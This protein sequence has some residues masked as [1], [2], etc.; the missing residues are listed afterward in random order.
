[1]ASLVAA[2][3][4]EFVFTLLFAFF[5]GLAPA[6]YAAVANG[7]ALSVLVYCAVSQSGG[8][9]NP[10]VTVALVASG[11]TSVAQGAA[12]VLC[13]LAGAIVGAGVTKGFL[14]SPGCFLPAAGVSH[15]QLWGWETIM[16]FLLIVTVYEM[17]VVQKGASNFAPLVIG[18]ALL[19][20]ALAGGPYTGAALNFAR[21]LGPA[22]VNGCGWSTVWV[23]LL[24]HATAAVLAAAWGLLVAPVGPYNHMWR[25]RLAHFMPATP[26]STASDPLAP[27]KRDG[28]DLSAAGSA[29]PPYARVTDGRTPLSSRN[30][31]LLSTR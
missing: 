2:L 11:H 7:L 4:S 28:K 27:Y 15:A 3:A 21:V 5:G 29:Y 16:T 20:A 23:Y 13:Q 31:H 12:Y 25:G 10:N 9:L 30:H 19:V 6:Q 18:L 14:R 22:A 8:H 26:Y 24:A 1:M 17:A